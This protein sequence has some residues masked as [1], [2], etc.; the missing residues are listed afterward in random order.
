[1]IKDENYYKQKILEIFPKAEQ[2][3]TYL[4]YFDDKTFEVDGLYLFIPNVHCK[5]IDTQVFGKTCFWKTCFYY[6]L[7]LNRIPNT[8]S[9]EELICDIIPKNKMVIYIKSYPTANY[10]LINNFDVYK[11]S[12][13]VETKISFNNFSAICD[14][15]EDFFRQLWIE[16]CDNVELKTLNSIFYYFEYAYLT[17]YNEKLTILDTRKPY[18]EYF[19]D[20][21]DENINVVDYEFSEVEIQAIFIQKEILKSMYNEDGV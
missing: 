17:A 20:D 9:Y 1:M 18:I 6:L 21:G 2:R 14:N 15:T 11:I 8:Y 4:Y 13:D 10:G 12:I 3:E 7:S 16:I 19:N 5:K